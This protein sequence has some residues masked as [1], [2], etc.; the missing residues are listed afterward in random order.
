MI[1]RNDTYSL[2]YSSSAVELDE[3]SKFLM[4]CEISPISMG[5]QES[6][7]GAGCANRISGE[8]ELLYIVEGEAVVTIDHKHYSCSSG[9]IVLIPPYSPNSIYIK[10]GVSHR[11]YWAHFWV[12][13]H[14]AHEEFAELICPGYVCNIGLDSSLIRFY[15]EGVREFRSGHADGKYVA[16]I[17]AL[18]QL[19]IR[20]IRMHDDDY[21][22]KEHGMGSVFAD[23]CV[24]YIYKNINEQY[25]LKKL[26]DI[27]GTTESYVSQAFL[28]T[29]GISPMR[30]IQTAKIKYGA[31]LLG[32]TD[33]PI[34]EIA[35]ELG[36]SSQY[37]FSNVFKQQ[38]GI[39]PTVF[40]NG[41]GKFDSD[42]IQNG[43]PV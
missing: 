23:K 4:T 39:S 22:I 31:L 38:Y 20:V 43:D 5:C 26:A 19:L 10:K 25:S 40:K 8:F 13:N 7:V 21:H 16:L 41:L 35:A 2:F 14:S 15:E 29:F 37:H 32:T 9:D 33:K 6:G 28:E 24:K 36:F 18:M 3:L 1:Y 27:M 34:K 17:S 12:G 11:N 30:F 42:I